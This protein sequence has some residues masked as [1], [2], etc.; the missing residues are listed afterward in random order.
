M[1]PPPFC[2][3]PFVIFYASRRRR[4]RPSRLAATNRTHYLELPLSLCMICRAHEFRARVCDAPVH[5][6]QPRACRYLSF[7]IIR[8]LACLL[9]AHEP[10]RHAFRV[11]FAHSSCDFMLVWDAPINTTPHVHA[12]RRLTRQYHCG[13]LNFGL[14]SL[15]HFRHSLRDHIS[16]R[17]CV[18]MHVDIEPEVQFSS[19]IR[20]VVI[21]MV[22]G[23]AGS[24]QLPTNKSEPQVFAPK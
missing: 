20:Q 15:T 4:A 21:M 11:E 13:R 22:H 5:F 7:C 17:C 24:E 8:R 10:L 3:K 1:F 6:C 2:R 12:C 14:N 18:D 19:P 23:R 16:N 9:V